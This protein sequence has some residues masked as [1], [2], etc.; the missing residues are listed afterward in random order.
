MK[1]IHWQW[2]TLTTAR[3]LFSIHWVT[4]V[5]LTS[6]WPSLGL[7]DSTRRGLS[8]KPNLCSVQQNTQ[9]NYAYT[10]GSVQAIDTCSVQYWTWLVIA[11]CTALTIRYPWLVG[12]CW[13]PTLRPVCWRPRWALGD[14]WTPSQTPF[15][16]FHFGP[17]SCQHWVLSSWLPTWAC[18]S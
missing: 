13:R 16:Q 4:F 6:L 7:A 11:S 8:V 17:L 12:G 18:P 1:H 14:N 3:S 10:L 2:L 15:E 5:I 9:Y